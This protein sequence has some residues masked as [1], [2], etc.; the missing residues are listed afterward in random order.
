M[1]AKV[2]SLTADLASATSRTALLESTLATT[3]KHLE[4]AL[5]DLQAARADA[6]RFAG[7]ARKATRENAELVDELETFKERARHLQARL[8]DAVEAARGT[9]GFVTTTTEE[10]VGHDWDEVK[11]RSPFQLKSAIDVSPS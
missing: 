3:Q 2:A 11:S 7:E 1:S 8:G 6:D 9:E 10:K 4:T 5:S